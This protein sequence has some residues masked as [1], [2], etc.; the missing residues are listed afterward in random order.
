MLSADTPALAQVTST[1][2]KPK[3]TT[4][5]EKEAKRSN[6][7]KVVQKIN[8]NTLRQ[9]YYQEAI[10]IWKNDIEKYGPKRNKHANYVIPKVNTLPF[11]RAWKHP[12]IPDQYYG[13]ED[14]QEWADR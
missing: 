14:V 8:P 7:V 3:P 13:F 1:P 11:P 5:V 6:E 12:T 2:L 10:Q 4:A 9:K